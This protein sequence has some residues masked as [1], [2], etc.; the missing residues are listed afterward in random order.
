VFNPHV[1]MPIITRLSQCKQIREIVQGCTIHIYTVVRFQ[2]VKLHNFTRV[3]Q[4][5]KMS[6]QLTVLTNRCSVAHFK[7]PSADDSL[8]PA[9]RRQKRPPRESF[10]RSVTDSAGKK[11]RPCARR[12]R[13]KDLHFAADRR[14]QCYHSL[15]M[16]GVLHLMISTTTT[17]VVQCHLNVTIDWNSS[18]CKTHQNK[19]S[20]QTFIANHP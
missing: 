1:C 7:P 13:Q 10:R 8:T 3:L 14:R 16:L 9:V 20:I 5:V 2:T 19:D 15:D 4:C 18:A 17:V 11:R 12:R 6:T